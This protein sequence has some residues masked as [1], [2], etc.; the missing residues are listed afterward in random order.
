MNPT[1]AVEKLRGN[2]WTQAEIAVAVDIGQAMVSKI[3]RGSEPSYSI[4]LRLVQLAKGKR[5]PPCYSQTKS[6]RR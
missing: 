3:S 1:E 4:G 5:N 6:A 2:G